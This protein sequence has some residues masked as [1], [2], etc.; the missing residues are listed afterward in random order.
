MQMNIQEL[1]TMAYHNLPI[2][3]FI[4][5]NFGYGII[6]QFQDTWFEG[7]YEATGKGYSYPDFKKVSEAYGI[8]YR[9]ITSLDDLLLDDIRSPQGLVIDVIL[10]PNT[11]IEPKIDSGNPLHNQS[12]Y[13]EI[14]QDCLELN[15]LN[16]KT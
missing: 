12:P 15:Y 3:I 10:H 1:Q 4:L 7:R 2:K 5:N 13:L 16:E 6:K 8:G 9:R 14:E 11:L